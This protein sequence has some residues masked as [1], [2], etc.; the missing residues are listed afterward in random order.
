MLFEFAWEVL[1]ENRRA[2]LVISGLFYGLVIATMLY[3]AV[4]PA[5]QTATLNLAGDS[6]MTGSVSMFGKGYSTGEIV[7]RTVVLYFGNLMGSDFLWIT[8]PS[9]IIPFSGLAVTA[10]H[11]IQW[12]LL[13]SPAN[14]AMRSA[15]ITHWLT[16]ALE[17]Q[18]N[19]LATLGAY[20]LGRAVIWPQSIGL[21]GRRAAYMEGLRQASALYVLVFLVLA[22]SGIYGLIEVTVLYQLFR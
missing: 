16:L 17:G 8:L 6:M 22:I 20:I 11:A 19:I 13:F 1:K 5:A 4:D 15:M 18:A 2:Y 7:T 3:A 14:P 12:G 9:M 21:T 10:F